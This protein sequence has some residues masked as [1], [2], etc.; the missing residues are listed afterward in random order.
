[1]GEW[2]EGQGR[3]G[4]EK[5]GGRW[6]DGRE[7]G[8]TRSCMKK[9]LS[10]LKEQDKEIVREDGQIVFKTKQVNVTFKVINILDINE[11]QS[12]VHIFFQIELTW[13]D[14]NLKYQFLNMFD[15][16]N[17]INEDLASKI[18]SPKIEF[19]H[20]I[21]EKARI[22]GKKFRVLRRSSPLLGINLDKNRLQ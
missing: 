22:L 15:D 21:D 17:D 2:E 12:V 1:M 8:R 9:D 3:E 20:T 14:S 18:W 7:M 4:D 19:I 11:E 13:Y 16:K 6:D 5:K 10:S